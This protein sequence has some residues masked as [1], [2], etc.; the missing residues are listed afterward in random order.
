MPHRVLARWVSAI[1]PGGLVLVSL[2][3]PTEVPFGADGSLV[4]ARL[5]ELLHSLG[6]PFVIGGDWN[7]TPGEL[8]A[9]GWA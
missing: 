4:L 7:A 9:Q 8:A 6:G 3:L 5:G 2:Y 1:I